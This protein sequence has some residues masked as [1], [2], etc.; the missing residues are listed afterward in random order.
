M[1]SVFL[2]LFVYPVALAA[3][4]GLIL[5]AGIIGAA[6]ILEK[7]HAMFIAA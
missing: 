5:P 7:L 2:W 6:W 1:V 3:A 4:G